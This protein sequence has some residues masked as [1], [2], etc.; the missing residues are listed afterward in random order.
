[1]NKRIWLSA[2]AMCGKEIEFINQAFKENW[3]AP[4]GPDV[5]AFEDEMCNYIS[6][7][8][9]VAMTTGTAAIHMA[10]KY[11]G[12]EN[13]DVV[14]CSSLTFA[15]S[16]N[17]IMYQNAVPVFIDS[18]PET[19]NMS[20]VAL[21]KAFD[22]YP[23]PKAVI[24]VNLYGQSA[25]MDKILEIC[26]NYNVPII[27]DAAESLGAIY[28][29]KASG[30]FGKFGV[31]SFNG[32]KI[33]TTSGGGMLICPDE[34]SK[35]RILKWITQSRDEAR[36][37]EHSELGF[38]YRMSNICAGI[39][40]GQLTAIGERISRKKEIYDTYKKAFSNINSIEM[41]PVCDYG[42]PN[43]WLSC[44]TIKV[45]CKINPTDIID[46]LEKENIESRPIWK[47]MHL[48]PFYKKYDYFTHDSDVSADI[49]ERGLCF[50]SDVNMTNDDV[51]RIIEI[52]RGRF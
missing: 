25:D 7:K 11:I 37:Y 15:A 29:G 30:T 17:P 3:V 5:D 20:S 2:P 13:G 45:G 23:N 49:F 42:E 43:Y 12:V 28:K 16:C 1:M 36:H 31:L 44:M 9:A 38:N 10:L 21:Q 46:A 40:R 41:M 39:G 14:F 35:K 22:K 33:I 18:E 48:Q 52:I 34:I 47:P 24:V 26:D 4:L 6:A 19:W 32:N 8:H 50:P 27:E 51:Q